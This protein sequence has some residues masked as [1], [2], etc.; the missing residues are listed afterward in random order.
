MWKR[1]LKSSIKNVMI[2]FVGRTIEDPKVILKPSLIEVDGLH[3]LC[4]Y[5]EIVVLYEGNPR[6]T[7][8]KGKDSNNS[9][10]NT[11]LSLRIRNSNSSTLEQSVCH[12]LCLLGVGR[13]GVG[14]YRSGVSHSKIRSNK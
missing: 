13:V 6:H 10:T 12:P 5:F 8:L 9:D 3:H 14:W 4:I 2:I 1:N 11:V 7:S